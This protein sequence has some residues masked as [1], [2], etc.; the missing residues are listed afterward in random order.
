[1]ETS[2]ASASDKDF[3]SRTVN[4][5]FNPGETGPKEVEFEIIDD[6]LVENTESFSVSVVSTSVS[7]VISGEPA[8]VNILD[9][10]GNYFPIACLLCC[11]YEP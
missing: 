8:T 2:P 9:N 7:G 11:Q 3:V 4:V 1:L 6:P 10:D 5:T